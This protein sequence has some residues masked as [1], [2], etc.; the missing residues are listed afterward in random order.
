[1]RPIEER[2]AGAENRS[3][4]GHLEGDLIV[5][6]QGTGAIVSTVD[7]KSRITRLGKVETKSS[8]EVTSK[9][10]EMLEPER[11]QV[12]SITFDR[13]KEF[14]GHQ[15][16][17]EYLEIQTFFAN[18]YSSW[19]R[20]TNENTNGL[21]RQYL[22]KGTSFEDVS[23]QDVKWIEDRLNNRPRKILDFKSPNEVVE[24]KLTRLVALAS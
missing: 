23:E 11:D 21:V 7:R 8:P 14:A 24:G 3:R 20:G 12:K 1:M 17:A 10:G 15:D 19:E 22:P 4:V 16:L 2:P 9:L 18:A 6:K 13:G 5:G